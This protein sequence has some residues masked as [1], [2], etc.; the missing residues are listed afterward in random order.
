MRGQI[1]IFNE[2]KQ[3]G[4]I[5]AA[6]GQRLLF[7]ISDWQDVLAPEA[8][9]SVD[10]QPDSDSRARQVQ[11]A[12]PEPTPA[13][14][15]TAMPAAPAVP[16]AQRPKRKPTLTLLALFLGGIGA[17]RFYMGAWGWGVAQLSLLLFIVILTELLPALGGLLWFA[18]TVFI[19][20]ETVRYI[21]MSDTEFDAK[22]QAW[23]ASQ[24]GPFAFFW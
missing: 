6:D 3:A 22:V 2:L 15:L 16:L 14:T 9:M 13:A 21:L 12:L 20:V 7:H 11:L 19:M 1:L 4:A 24:P 18:I 17:H 5:V 23:Q 10:F 8:G